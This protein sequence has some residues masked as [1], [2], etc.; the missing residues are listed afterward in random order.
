ML[1]YEHVKLREVL[2]HTKKILGGSPAGLPT[3]AEGQQPVGVLVTSDRDQRV[4]DWLISQVGSDAVMAACERISGRR[5]PYVSNVAKVLGLN[6][7]PSLV[8]APHDVARQ[9]LS[10][11]RAL[12][13]RTGR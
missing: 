10:K 2:L 5:R 8:L 12:L 3:D 9:H 13:R 11:F 7:P 1:Q 4:L 6:P